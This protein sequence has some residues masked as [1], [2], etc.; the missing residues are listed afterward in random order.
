MPAFNAEES[1]NEC[2]RSILNQSLRDI[3]VVVVDDGSTDRTA[4]IVEELAAV[5]SRLRLIRATSAGAG[6]ARNLG[7]SHAQG[8]FLAFA[9]A[10]DVVL[11]GAYAAM[12]ETL[13]RTGSNFVS[14]GYV[15][16]G[17]AG[18]HRPAIVEKGHHVDRRA[19][20]LAAMP[21]IL[22]EPVLWN[23]V[24][25]RTVWD[26]AVP[27]IPEEVNY[28]DQEPT[29]RMA[30]APGTFDVLNR[31][32]YAWRLP[33]GRRS[34]SQNKQEI[35]DL[36]D[37]L[38]VIDRLSHLVDGQQEQVRAHVFAK[39]LGSDL[40]LHAG[41]VPT[42][43]DEYWDLLA[44]GAARIARRAPQATWTKMPAQERML[45]AVLTE[46][47]R[48]DVEEILATRLEDTTS[49]PFEP[50]A[51]G[52]EIAPSYLAR[53]RTA[54][55]PALLDV[56]PVDLRLA[57]SVRDVE[58]E[59]PDVLRVRGS[60]YVPG[61][62]HDAVTVP[63]RIRAIRE[64]G[65]EVDLT[66]V[67]AP[68]SIVDESAA[69]PWRSYAMTG[70][71]GTVHVPHLP[72]DGSLTFVAS[73][74]VGEADVRASVKVRRG[75]QRVWPGPVADDHRN[76]ARTD[77]YDRL[78]VQRVA[79]QVLSHAATVA[80]RDVRVEV[81]DRD[82][83]TTEKVVL[84][85][86]TDLCELL[87]V[88]GPEGKGPRVFEGR[89][90][91]L[92]G[93]LLVA[94]ER[95]WLVEGVDREG[96]S[97]RVSSGPSS[98]DP[99]SR[100][101]SVSD[102][103]G[104][105]VVE[106]RAR[107]VSVTRIEA[108]RGEEIVLVGRADPRPEVFRVALSSSRASVEPHQVEVA[109]D[110]QFR[111]RFTISTTDRTQRRVALPSN[112]FFL[113]WSEHVTG[114]VDQWV[115][116]AGEIVR[117]E[118][119]VR[120]VDTTV[121]AETRRDGSVG[122]NVT[123]PLTAEE[124]TRRGQRQLRAL[125]SERPLRPAVL[126]ESFNGKS[127]ADNP[128]AVHLG[129]RRA[130]VTAPF[131]WSVTDHSVLL[132]ADAIPL[133]TGSREWHMALKSTKVLI[134]NNNFPHY[135]SKSDGQFFIQ[136]WHGVPLKRLLL[137]LPRSRVPPTY[138]R[139]M[140][141]QVAQWDLLLAPDEQAEKDLRSGLGYRGET[142]VGPQARDD[143]LVQGTDGRHQ[144][145]RSRLGIGVDERIVLYAPTWRDSDRSSWLDWTTRLQL[146]RLAAS[147]GARVLL[148]SHHMTR[149]RHGR[150][151]GVF[152]VSSYPKAE[153]LLLVSDVLVTDYSSILFDFELTG[154]PVV[155]YAPDLEYYR[156]EE[157]GFYR[158]WPGASTWPIARD[159]QALEPLVAEALRS[160]TAKAVTS[161]T[162]TLFD[163]VQTKIHTRVADA[164]GR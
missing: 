8:T 160:V 29:L 9:D 33:E 52:L 32:V 71:E 88:N 132:P 73:A 99:T 128:G 81:E 12:V 94:G 26:S 44:D 137:D 43:D 80:G 58:W 98:S 153:D 147:W 11:P 100:G 92:S 30:L 6:A 101:R 161:P 20:T 31:D 124:R 57:G 123:A 91:P 96:R 146:D 22:D 133:V 148:R 25:R 48:V 86:G 69:D 97:R 2:L 119:E 89:L 4:A 63:V 111:A 7:I 72:D 46:G 24:Y 134:S 113:R 84:R 116:G 138:R 117:R 68:D 136:T 114:E 35:A 28:E 141:R 110:G 76:V 50:G 19:T 164:L 106:E 87:P 127:G 120:L 135:F 122:V 150:G 142:L 5:D 38:D 15:R 27:G 78:V 85:Q 162:V 93:A 77:H 149:G 103:Q 70:F 34:R 79:V 105:L 102:D 18:Q 60:F 130:G 23:K 21:E 125:V 151:P 118:F 82:G 55:A 131:Y 156:D 112:G 67:P 47:S 16:T 90:P 17:G 154:R 1:I 109:G 49:V 75:P 40:A 13:E 115:R 65:G 53:L 56:Q 144:E 10:D 51:R 95:R 62:D 83:A 42:S 74:G 39:W 129:L 157:R 155:H 45:A 66:L 139:L 143:V 3:D 14:G 121:R 107:R 158:G 159:Q 64:D 36:R 152:D 61:L 54:I 145:V 104:C 37:R 41:H 108:G 126:F 163:D 59:A 140:E